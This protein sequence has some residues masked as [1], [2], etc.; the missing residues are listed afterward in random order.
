MMYNLTTIY[1][2]Y[3]NPYDYWISIN[4]VFILKK[5]L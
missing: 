4:Q 1:P 2:N 3:N 5:K